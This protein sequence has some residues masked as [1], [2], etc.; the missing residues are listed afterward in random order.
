[1]K[2]GL[3]IDFYFSDE[4]ILNRSP[5][6]TRCTLPDTSHACAPAPVYTVDASH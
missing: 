3:W 6:A 5:W 4:K 1:M 2:K